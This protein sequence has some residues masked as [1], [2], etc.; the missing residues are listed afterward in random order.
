MWQ[1]QSISKS[2]T[3]VS[4]PKVCLQKMEGGLGL[5]RIATWNKE[6]VFKHIWTLQEIWPL[7]TIQNRR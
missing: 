3:K 6:A 2:G 7:A 1:G 5:K 4:W